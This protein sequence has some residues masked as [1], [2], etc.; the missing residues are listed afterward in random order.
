[1]QAT[2]SVD[3]GLGQTASQQSLLVVA[4]KSPSLCGR[5]WLATFNLLPRQVNATQMDTTTEEIVRPM[6]LEFQGIFKPGCG[7]LKG[8]PVHVQIRHNAQPRYYRPRSVP[9]ELL[10]KVEEELLRLEHENIITPVDHSDWASP[11]VPVLKADGQRVRICGDSKIGVNPTVVTTQYPLSKVED[12]F[13]SLQGGP[14]FSKLDF[15]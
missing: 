15:F 8:P 14:K 5:D 1:M 4:C 2:L 12:I 9:Y 10:V 3:V 11:I 7:T 6:L 13:A